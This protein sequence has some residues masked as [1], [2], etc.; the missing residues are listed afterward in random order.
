MMLR[1]NDTGEPVKA[2]QRDLNK[3]GSMLTIDGQFG[4][5]TQAAVGDARIALAQP[6]PSTSADAAL[7]AALAAAPDPFVAITAPGGTFVARAEV[8][9][10]QTYRAT[11]RIPTWPSKD[12]GI[13]IGIGYD[14]RFV[15]PAQLRADWGGVLAEQ[16]LT[17]LSAV[18]HVVGSDTR[19]DSV[20]DVDVP[21]TGAMTVF[22]RRSIPAYL[23]DVRRIYPQVDALS[24]ARQTALVSLVYN[25]GPRLKDKDSA[26]EDRREMRAIQDLLAT[27]TLDAVAEQF[28]RMTRLWDPQKLAGLVQ[29]RRNEA[30]LWR[31]G[32]EALQLV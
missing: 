18:T 27:N 3:L 24:P 23:G 6:G 9:S 29:R 30:T 8:T 10:P 20:R 25:R 22:A 7:I 16:A 14:L 31:S 32:F 28:E 2:L 17:R 15:T 21:L 26:V 11:Y 1:A 4:P 5:S 12:S 13:T 19:R